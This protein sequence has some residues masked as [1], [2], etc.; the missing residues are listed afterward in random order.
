MSTTDLLAC[1]RGSSASTAMGDHD[2]NVQLDN[3]PLDLQTVAWGRRA[4]LA[5]SPFEGHLR[6]GRKGTV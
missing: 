4:E 3:C 1:W 6:F 5:T 2:E